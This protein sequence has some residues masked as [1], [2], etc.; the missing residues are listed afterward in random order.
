MLLWSQEVSMIFL[1]EYCALWYYLVLTFP[2]HQQ[3]L[4]S[5]NLFHLTFPMSTTHCLLSNLFTYT[6]FPCWAWPSFI[7]PHYLLSTL[8]FLIFYYSA[9]FPLQVLH[10]AYHS[11]YLSH[12]HTPLTSLSPSFLINNLFLFLFSHFSHITSP[13]NFTQIPPSNFTE[14]WMWHLPPPSKPHFIIFI[15]SCRST[16]CWIC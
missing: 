10:K 12:T 1:H 3:K 8:I 15:I 6:I 7:I 2:F 9:L 11:A 16:S 4:F 5:G 14:T 13:S